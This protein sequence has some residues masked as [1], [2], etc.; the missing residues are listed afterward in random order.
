MNKSDLDISVKVTA[1]VNRLTKSICHVIF[2]AEKAIAR[3]HRLTVKSNNK[4][5]RSG[6][7]YYRLHGYLT[8]LKRKRRK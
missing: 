5:R 6:K 8:Y 4:R 1:S 7:P 3:L 2:A